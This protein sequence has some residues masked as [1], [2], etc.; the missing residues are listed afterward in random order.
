MHTRVSVLRG[1]LPISL[2]V[3]LA[4]ALYG[5]SLTTT[6]LPG[7]EANVY[8]AAALTAS[9][10]TPPY[11]SWTVATGTLPA[12]LVLNAA[13]G[14]ISGTPTTVAVS[15]FSITVQ[16]SLG[17]VSAAQSLSIAITP[18]AT[19]PGQSE[20]L[21]VTRSSSIQPLL[22]PLVTNQGGYDTEITIS[23]TSQDT[24]TPESGTCT[25][26]YYGAGAPAPSTQTT[27]S[28][29]A[30]KQL[31]F[32]ISQVAPGFEGYLIG[33][34]AFPLARG[35]ARTFIAGVLAYSEDAQLVTLPRSV[36][37]TQSLLI[38]FATNQAGFDTGITIA[39]TSADPFGDTTAAAGTCTL[40]FYGTG[41]PNPNTVTTPSIAGGAVYAT[42][43]SAIA[44]GFQGYIVAQCFGAAVG[45][46]FVSNIETAV[47]PVGYS[48]TPEVIALPRSSYEQPLLFSSVINQNGS[49]TGI[50]IA[51]TSSD[52]FAAS[53]ANPTAGTCTLNFYGANPPALPF[54]T[55][56]ISAGTVYANTLSS[57]APG[58]KGYITASCSFPEARGFSFVA[59]SATTNDYSVTPEV[60]PVPRSAANSSLL[61]NNV[62]NQNANDTNIT[63]SNTSQDS[64]GTTA[65]AGSCTIHWYGAMASGGAVPAAQVSSSIAA[66][67][68]LSF[69]VSQGNATAGI[70][71]APGF[72]GYVIADCGFPLARGVAG[73][74]GTPGG[75]V[76]TTTTLPGGTMGVNY[77]QTLTAGN[78]LQPYSNWTVASGS[79]PPGLTLNS[80]TGVIAGIPSTATGSPFSFAV[81][82]HDSLGNVSA[83][84]SL[85]IAIAAPLF[86][87]T[88]VTPNS[89]PLNGAATPIVVAGTNFTGSSTV[90][91]SPPGNSATA[92]STTFVSA[93]Q[94]N[95]TIPITLLTTAGTAEVSVQTTTAGA[96]TIVSNQLPFTVVAPLTITNNSNLGSRRIGQQ[97]ITLNAS[98]GSGNYTWSLASGSLPPGFNIATV[99]GSSPVQ[100]GLVG[101]L[102]TP[103][104]YSFSL[105][106]NDG[107]TSVT[108][109]FTLTVTGLTV[110][111]PNLPDAFVNTAYS[112]TF[113]VLTTAGAVTFTPNATP[114]LPA[115]MSLSAAGVLSGTP[116]TAG[117]YSINFSVTDGVS[118]IGAGYQ[119]VV[120]AV[121]LTT[122]GAL[123][124]ATQGVA[125]SAT[126]AASGGSGGYHYAIT[127][128]GLPSGFS[129]SS[130]GV[131]S[132][133]TNTST[134]IY[135]FDVTVTDS[136]NHSYQKTMSIDVIGST[137][138]QM[139]FNNPL[140]LDDAVV[141]DTYTSQV[142]ICCGGTAPFTWTATGLPAGMSIRSGSGVT[143]DYIPPGNGEIWGLA[144]TP[145]TYNVTVKVTDANGSSTSLAFPFHV[146]VLNLAT[147]YSLPNGTLNAPY[148]TTFQIIGGTT[149]YG[150]VVQDSGSLP[151][152]LSLNTASVAAGN[153]TVAGTPLENGG[154]DPIFTT[155]DGAGNTLTRN[156]Y[157]NIFNVAGGITINN[158]S[159]L[160]SVPVG[161]NA[162]GQLSACC[163][164]NY[165]WSVVSGNTPPGANL[166]ATGAFSGTLTTAGTYTFLVKAADAA[167]VAAPG[168]SQF[169]VDVTPISISPN[170]LPYGNVGTA[171]NANFTATGGTGNLTWSVAFGSFLPPGL[172]LASN[173]AISGTPTATGQ[174]NF[175]INVADQGNH[176]A[177]SN[178]IINI[179]AAGAFPPLLAT[180]ANFGTWNM[181]RSG[182]RSALTAEMARI[183]GVWFPERC[184]PEWLCARMYRFSSRPI[185][186][187]ASSAWP[188][189]LVLTISR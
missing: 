89:A 129:L 133:T 152:G 32:K 185:S 146:S 161:S 48:I 4:G 126:L 29:A 7:G 107:N 170:S 53:G 151:D 72:R 21:P 173:G 2:C 166:S 85:S 24:S 56:T 175:T 136:S 167:G 101:I 121:N 45:Y 9:G 109:A 115:G 186:R 27:A 130:G 125:Y 16:D 180:G 69:T 66:G 65:A 143:S 62:T 47:Y 14:V 132:G 102:T 141:G 117:T 17:H 112:Y 58:F 20:V 124:N 43:L 11:S 179:Y 168:F 147:N 99:P 140:T 106:V 178:Y 105:T 71:G 31:I 22:F 187:P 114:V 42:L 10:G 88:S 34:C 119:L 163:V 28:I 92:L 15:S 155:T 144:S 49:D 96:G 138:T 131:I 61:F 156:N 81:T 150:S 13:T 26:Y 90:L 137:P 164:A 171:Y 3:L 75:L 91:F 23:N 38:P 50:A 135:G 145:G 148:S 120:Y 46:A 154:F 80:T 113:T 57:L 76:I 189:R 95:A 18:F 79:L 157:F 52:P 64:F 86:T 149:P 118:T 55:P 73:I 104:N 12:G 82:V 84:R 142:P 68:Q 33:G 108:S 160:G 165:I 183:P 128:G 159:N 78:G 153:F 176:T 123:P 30:G 110:K 74:Q 44:P 172:T 1:L 60:V 188:Q 87:V 40:N 6:S 39:N 51:N 54:V 182:L 5:Q 127:S 177:T 97:S 158:N 36:P 162:S 174:Y 93:A 19:L 169:T 111:D 37:A 70:A 134:G 116:T 25:L 94:L 59:A 41:A 77:S 63:I 181:E 98:G 100:T 83:A 35:A 184:R 103:G 67:S 122:P 139:Q 8:Y